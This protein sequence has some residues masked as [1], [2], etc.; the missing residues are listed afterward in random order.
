MLIPG[1]VF[2]VTGGASGLG[3]GTVRALAAKG[4]HVV[5]LDRDVDRAAA[6]VEEVINH[7]TKSILRTG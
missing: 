2:V 7:T 1:G 6:I 3:E 4:A 5:I